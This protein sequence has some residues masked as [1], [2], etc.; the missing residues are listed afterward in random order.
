LILIL[1]LDEGIRRALDGYFSDS[2]L[3]PLLPISDSEHTGDAK[4]LASRDA[5][6]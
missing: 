3:C 5:G 1:L 6:L 4:R 2:W